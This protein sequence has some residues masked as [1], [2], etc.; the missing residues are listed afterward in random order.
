[1]ELFD[2]TIRDGGYINDWNFSKEQVFECY[3]AAVHSGMSYCEIGFR[4]SIPSLGPWYYTPENLVNETFHMVDS[5]CK[6]A[7]MAQMGTFTIDDFVAKQNSKISMVRLLIAY[8]C[9][10]VTDDRF[11]D[12]KLI[13]DTIEMAHLLHDMGYE[14]SINI[15]RIDNIPDEHIHTICTMCQN[16]PIKYLYIADTYGSIGVVHLR[17]LLQEMKKMYTKPIG[18]HGHNNLSN[19]SIKSIDALYNGAS[20]VDTTFGGTGRGSGNAMTELVIAHLMKLN[21]KTQ[22]NIMA[23]FCYTDMYVKPSSE[24]F[25]HMMS[26]YHRMHVNYANEMVKRNLTLTQMADAFSRL[27]NGCNYSFFNIRDFER[28]V[29]NETLSCM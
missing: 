29:T 15:G 27:K 23:A 21:L 11:L 6:L 7:V 28:C 19:A 4:R 24:F 25:A 18:F 5:N 13:R 1:M 10:S 3:Q 9:G 26:G 20:I 2:C 16:A 8:H 12:V 22:T 17:K 14:V